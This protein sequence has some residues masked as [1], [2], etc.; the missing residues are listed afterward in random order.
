MCY[1]LV[2]KNN[3]HW[4][5]QKNTLSKL[6]YQQD[7]YSVILISFKFRIYPSGYFKKLFKFFRLPQSYLE[8]SAGVY[9]GGFKLKSELNFKKTVWL[10]RKMRIGFRFNSLE[11]SADFGAGGI[12]GAGEC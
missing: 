4:V 9:I 7:S 8:F 1:Q 6:M 10:S 11:F 12:S 2:L 5:H 3:R